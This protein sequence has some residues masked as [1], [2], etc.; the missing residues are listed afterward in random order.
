MGKLIDTSLIL[1]LKG[2]TMKLSYDYL[3]DIV[4]HSNNDISDLIEEKV[5]EVQS[6]VELLSED[7]ML[8]SLGNKKKD[9][10]VSLLPLM[11]FIKEYVNRESV[12]F[13]SQSASSENKI[14][15]NSKTTHK[16]IERLMSCKCIYRLDIPYKVND[17]A[18][19]YYVCRENFDLLMQLCQNQN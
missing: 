7:E 14:Y 4:Y 12:V 2:Y 8:K 19:Y 10:L 5:A 17:R 11:N 6:A 16:W 3:L 9:A 1:L 13:I 18:Y 15:N